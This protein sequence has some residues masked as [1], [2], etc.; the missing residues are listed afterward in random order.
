[1]TTS[2]FYYFMQTIILVKP[3]CQEQSWRIYSIS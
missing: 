2:H 3:A 1:M